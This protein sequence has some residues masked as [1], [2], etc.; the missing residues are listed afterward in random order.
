LQLGEYFNIT[1]HHFSGIG[2]RFLLEAIRDV[3]N[4]KELSGS[5]LMEVLSKSRLVPAS[6]PMK[7]RE[8]YD[9]AKKKLEEVK[10]ILVMMLFG[11]F[12]DRYLELVGTAEMDCHGKIVEKEGVDFETIHV[13]DEET[14]ED[15]FYEDYDITFGVG[16]E[17]VV[18]RDRQRYIGNGFITVYK[19]KADKP[20]IATE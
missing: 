7:L 3:K 4:A 12:R 11:E 8:E 18:V 1:P 19:L 13:E 10:N 9:E 2:M 14:I 20:A 15:P 17:Y 5:V 6:P 16:G